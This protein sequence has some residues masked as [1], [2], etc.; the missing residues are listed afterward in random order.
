[1]LVARKRTKPRRIQTY[2]YVACKA[3]LEYPQYQRK[4][5][6]RSSKE[7]FSSCWECADGHGVIVH[8]KGLMTDESSMERGVET[9]PSCHSGFQREKTPFIIPIHSLFHLS[10]YLFGILSVTKIWMPGSLEMSPLCLERVALH[11]VFVNASHSVATANN[12]VIIKEY[13]DSPTR[14]AV[15]CIFMVCVPRFHPN[16]LQW[17]QSS[18]HD[19]SFFIKAWHLS[20]APKDLSASVS[21]HPYPA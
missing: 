14:E 2:M 15:G 1:M 5:S 18:V 6:I 19:A 9:I 16:K 12:N 8:G 17:P 3:K 7:C 20:D 4:A 10:L 11:L 21:M 13:T